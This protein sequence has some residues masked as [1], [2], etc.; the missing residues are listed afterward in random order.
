MKDYYIDS[1]TKSDWGV[2]QTD[3]F[4]FNQDQG[5]RLFVVDNFYEDPYEVR[6]F[7][8]QQMYYDDPGY[9]GMRTRKQFFFEGIKEKFEEIIGQKIIDWENQGMNGRFQTC[10]AGTPLVYHCDDQRWAAMVYLTPDAPPS[11]GTSFFRH[12]EIKVHHNSQI[13]WE[14]GDGLKV[15]NQKTFLDKTPYELVDQ[16]GNIFNR[17]VIFDGGLIHSAS[18]Y[19]GWDIASSRLFHMYFFN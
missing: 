5:K 9:L 15:F 11:C 4:R 2:V 8:L 10:V 17:L 18:E 12:R 14:N 7:A 1:D 19:F 13:N 16:V 3:K 6:N